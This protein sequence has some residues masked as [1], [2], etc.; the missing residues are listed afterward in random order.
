MDLQLWRTAANV[1][2]SRTAQAIQSQLAAV[3][4]R[5]E[6]IERDASSQ[7]EA[8][9]TGQ[10]DMVILD[11][12]ADYPDAD[13]FLYPLFYSGSF[14]PGGNYAFYSH[15]VTD[16]LIL[17]A[18]RT[19]A[20]AARRA[21]PGRPAPAAVR[22]LSVGRAARRLRALLHHATTD[23]PRPGRALPQD[24]PA[25]PRRHAARRVVRHHAGSGV[26]GP[27]GGRVRPACHAGV[28]CRRVVSRVLG[29]AAADPRVRAGAPL[30]AAVGLGRPRVSRLAGA[31][32][33]D[34]L[35]RVSVPD[36][37]RCHARRAVERF[38]AHGAGQGIERGG[39]D[40][41]PRAPQRARAG[42]H[43]ARPRH[44]ELSDRQHS[45]RDHLRLAGP[46]ALR[47]HRDREARP[48]GDPGKRPVHVPRVRAGEPRDG[49]ALCEG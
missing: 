48:A 9:R 29:G 30:A 15:G 21:A 11:W 6:L 4:V 40:P 37:A 34:A 10:T 35:G 33:R 20:A 12:W 5:V 3:G 1:E 7:R 18:R 2:L 49:R 47:A 45:H 39:R 17:A 19:T 14:G 46:G 13:N 36:H 23:R 44:G 38:R 41:A 16:S 8:A 27:A 28:V 24:G 32:A 26:G 31:D 22:A 42:D 43:G 25:R